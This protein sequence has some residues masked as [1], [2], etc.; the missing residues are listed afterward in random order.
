MRR[1]NFGNSTNSVEIPTALVLSVSGKQKKKM[2]NQKI[3]NHKSQRKWIWTTWT[4]FILSA[5]GFLL[6]IIFSCSKGFNDWKWAINPELA[7]QFGSLISGVVGSLFSLAGFFLLYETI[8]KQQELFSIQQFESKYF[9]LIRIHRENV[10]NIKYIIPDD[11]NEEQIEGQSYFVQLN[12]EFDKLYAI[13][14]NYCRDEIQEET[15]L[16]ALTTIILF[17]GVSKKTLPTL[18]GALS[19]FSESLVNN[20]IHELRSI[21]TNYDKNIV[22]FGGHQNR[23][24]HYLRHLSQTIKYIDKQTFLNHEAKYE[25]VKLVRAQLNQYEIV[26]LFYN[27]ISRYGISWRKYGLIDR[28]QLIKNLPIQLSSGINPKTHYNS[29]I[30][31]WEEK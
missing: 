1:V 28:Y 19:N 4:A 30:F 10:Q 6:L 23:L 22:Y 2:N 18:K 31:D 15:K 16:I 9:E 26:N 5:L 24:G 13:V 20:L 11:E 27:S 25:Y 29:V 21:K 7:D 17:Y 8:I 14:R 3:D 12:H